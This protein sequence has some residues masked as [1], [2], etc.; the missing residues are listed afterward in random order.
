MLFVVFTGLGV[1]LDAASSDL[2]DSL[3]TKPA[4]PVK[5]R[6]YSYENR[7]GAKGSG[8]HTFGKMTRFENIFFSCPEA[9]S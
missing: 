2:A 6:W 7:D 9:Q 4:H 3:F 1:S 8:G 5:T